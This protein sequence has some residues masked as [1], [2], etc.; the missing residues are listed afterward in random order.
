MPPGVREQR[1]S[2]LSLLSKR[3]PP[4]HAARRVTALVEDYFV[5]SC[6]YCCFDFFFDAC[7]EHN[8]G[9]G[10]TL[11]ERFDGRYDVSIEV[12]MSS[13]VLASDLP[14]RSAQDLQLNIKSSHPRPSAVRQGAKPS[15]RC[16]ATASRWSIQKLVKHG[17]IAGCVLHAPQESG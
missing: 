7:E 6:R 3:P 8:H 13:S 14:Q 12:L 2:R 10:D 16:S 9:R 4:R 17:R 15:A 1:A 11:T 5:L